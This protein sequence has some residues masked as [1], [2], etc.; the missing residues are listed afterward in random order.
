MTIYRWLVVAALL[1][2]PFVM[3]ESR[4]Y[5][6]LL[7]VISLLAEISDQLHGRIR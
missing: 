3:I 5:I 2:A 7:A 4:T 1:V 6:G